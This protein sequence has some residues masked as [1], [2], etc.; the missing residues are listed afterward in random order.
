[1]FFWRNEHKKIN[2]RFTWFEKWI[3]DRRVYRTLQAEMQ[4]SSRSI[5]RLF[6]KYLTTAPQIPVKSKSN[7]HLLIDGT[8]LPNGLC[9]IL[10]YDHDIRYVQLYRTSSQEKFREIYQDLKALKAL[11]VQ[12]YSVTCD[13]HKSILKA[14]AKAYPNAVVQRCVVH[15]KRQC[16]VYLSRK[17]K[18]QASK[19]LLAISNQLTAVKTQQECSYWLLSLH[20]W[21]Q[22]HRD[23]LLEESVN[24]QSGDYWK[25]HDRLHRTYT[26]LHQ[27][28][29]NLF[30]YLNDPEIPATTNRLESFF[31]HLKEKLLLHSGLRLEAKRNFIKWYLHFKNKSSN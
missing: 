7:V 10:Y 30:N 8:Y 1:M 29:P 9:L 21:Y 6:K 12:V 26:H 19:E 11:G 22:L 14:V 3:M 25:T 20:N 4:M 31:K 18:L 24:E 13:G 2:N 23:T 27:A 15:V 17:P 28:I 16:R 5:S